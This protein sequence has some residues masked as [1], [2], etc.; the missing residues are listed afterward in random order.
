MAESFFGTLKTERVSRTVY[1]TRR[2][3][4]ADI[5]RYIEFWYN[6][7]RLHS[8]LGYKT[9]HEVLNEWTEQQAAA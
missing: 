9:P 7:E 4:Q 3:A 2:H 8:S 1:P 6:P 5:T